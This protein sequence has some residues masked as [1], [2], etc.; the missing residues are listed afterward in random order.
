M[1]KKGSYTRA[2]LFFSCHCK[3]SEDSLTHKIWS[4]PGVALLSFKLLNIP[5]QFSNETE[6]IYDLQP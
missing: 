5:G 2:L 6:A 3:K 4:S 1:F